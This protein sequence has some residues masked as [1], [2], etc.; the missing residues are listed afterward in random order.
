M[1]PGRRRLSLLALAMVTFSACATP[2][3]VNRENPQDVHRSL[4][5]NVLSTG[6]PSAP[7]RQVLQRLDLGDLYDDDPKAALETLREGLPPKNDE[8][9]IFALAELSFQTADRT[10][11][12][13][14][15]LAAA[16]YA[17]AFLFPEDETAPNPFDPR[18]RLACDLYNR[19]IAEGLTDPD[20][21]HF[22]VHDGPYALPFGTLDVEIDPTGFRWGPYVLGPFVSAADYRVRGLANRY[23]RPGLGA[24]LAAGLHMPPG[25]PIPKYGVAR[26][27]KVPVTAVLALDGARAGLASGEIHGRLSLYAENETATVTLGGR[28]VPLE[29]ETTTPLAYSL[30][31]AKIWDW[32]L[33]G[34]L[35]GSAQLG[36]GGNLFFLEPYEPGR[37]PVVLVHGTASSPARW[38]DLV[39]ELQADPGIRQNYQVWL[40]TYNTGNP[41][42]YSASQLRDAL[43]EAVSALDPG[44]HDP[45]LR[46][47]VVIGHSQGGLLA[48]LTV[49][50]SGSKFWENISNK[51][52]D[53]LALS[54]DTRQLLRHVLFVKPLPEVKRVVFVAT[55]H[56]GSYRTYSLVRDVFTWLFTAPVQIAKVGIDLG[57]ALGADEDAT[58]RRRLEHLPS[59]IDNMTPG[60]PFLVALASMPIAPGVHVHSIIAAEGTGKA[61]D[62]SDGVVRYESAHIE[63]VD[64]E[65]LIRSG[66]SVQAH[67][68]MIAEVRRILLLHLGISEPAPNEAKDPATKEPPQPPAPPP[69]AAAPA[70]P[71]PP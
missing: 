31:G 55:P 1:R 63:P 60:N 67:P 2:I 3:G 43:D 22:R 18:M 42:I 50:D 11:D 12:R 41:I 48:K 19:G 23:R 36:A 46:D 24:P 16:V 33:T 34:L 13:S 17:Y 49:V 5:A 27:L 70:G 7:S 8:D 59:S 65:V 10:G 61:E 47:M 26:S 21:V 40:F 30:E 57:R 51:P 25:I 71:A 64:S 20:D 4:V 58:L 29:Y 32:E 39:N 62:L 14:Y 44:G 56:H 54:P 6:H 53:Q 28:E 35:S 45:A 68:Q 15:Y 52:L 69:G 37:I 38:A 9:R 66:H